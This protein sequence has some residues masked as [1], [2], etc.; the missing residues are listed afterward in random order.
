MTPAE[1]RYCGGCGGRLARDNTAAACSPCLHAR[2]TT[3]NR[4]PDVTAEFWQTDQMRDALASRDMSVVVRA[5]RH[6]PVHGRKPLP[7]ATMSR[8]LNITQGQLSRI[9]SGQNRVR[10]L[11]KLLHYARQLRIPA[12]L[13]WFDT[14]TNDAPP[15]HGTADKI[16]L[17][18]GPTLPA[19]T[20]HT[21]PALAESLL[22]T[23]QHYATTDNLA[24]PRS[25]LTIV[26]QQIAF[27]EQLMHKDRTDALLYAA[28]RY[29]EF[30][31]WLNQDA[32][33]LEAAMRWS[34]TA[35]DFAQEA[36]DQHLLSYIRMRKSNIASDA[37]KP[38]LALA[39]ARAALQNPGALS[40]RLR[41][42]ALRQ[43]AHAHALAGNND[44][45]ARALDHAFQLVD[46]APE[47][48]N[49]LARYCTTSFIEMEAA[50][51]W[52]ELGK[53]AKAITT[54]Q[55][56]LA[57]WHADFRRDLGLCLARLAVAHASDQQPDNAV[58]VVDHAVAIAV[59]TRSQRTA[60]QLHRLPGI[61][62]ATGA[63]DQAQRI[64][65]TLKALR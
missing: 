39:Y 16:A 36:G 51:C 46:E 59:D 61:L 34:N 19:A 6:H 37:R 30:A 23:L 40:P 43:E 54:L 42:V 35:L 26:P 49:D 45:C 21:G 38:A 9:E 58:K 2:R 50:H 14:D 48:P 18:N 63:T 55:Q 56:G 1:A 15:R 10:D 28:S 60:R 65:H 8:W 62:A 24:G 12:E 47:D 13:L 22:A 29:A 7:Q 41:A 31:G 64:R 3:E 57:E 5:Y 11:D 53:P 52:V 27:I 17:P 44:S 33:Q 4:A 20:A 32:G 25:L